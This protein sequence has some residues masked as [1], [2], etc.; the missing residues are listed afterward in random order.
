[1]PKQVE[2]AAE[3]RDAGIVYSRP[4][5]VGSHDLGAEEERPEPVAEDTLVAIGAGTE[6]TSWALAVITY[7]LLA[8]P[9]MLKRLYPEV[10][11]AVP[12]QNRLLSW[13]VLEKLPYLGAGIQKGLRLSYGV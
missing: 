4:T 1:M 7:N 9:E 3:D 6:T 8:K 13:T 5:V 10:S 11:E 12:D 2:K